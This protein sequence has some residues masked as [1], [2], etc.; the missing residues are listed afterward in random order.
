MKRTFWTESS[1]SATLRRAWRSAASLFSTSRPVT[2]CTSKRV[3]SPSKPRKTRSQTDELSDGVF[4]FSQGVVLL[5]QVASQLLEVLLGPLQVALDPL[6]LELEREPV[7]RVA[8]ALLSDA[9]LQEVEIAIPERD[10]VAGIIQIGVQ[11]SDGLEDERLSTPR[12]H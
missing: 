10:A 1:L 7:V 9:L 8:L 11:A 6:D 5:G 3:R 12:G 4:A 2:L